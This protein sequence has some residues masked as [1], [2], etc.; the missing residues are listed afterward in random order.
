MA[1]SISQNRTQA[2]NK[3]ACEQ[4]EEWRGKYKRENKHGRGQKRAVREKRSPNNM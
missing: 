2:T 1:I 3:R 4:I